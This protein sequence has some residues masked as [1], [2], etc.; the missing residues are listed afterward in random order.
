MEMNYWNIKFSL[1]FHTTY[2]LILHINKLM[3]LQDLMLHVSSHKHY[4]NHKNDKIKWVQQKLGKINQV[5]LRKTLTYKVTIKISFFL[6]I[7]YLIFVII[8][9]FKFGIIILAIIQ[10]IQIFEKNIYL[11]CV[12]EEINRYQMY[13]LSQICYIFGL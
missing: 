9:L 5:L 13:I 11:V 4:N 3:Q 12:S 8:S 10:Q 1:P 2:L 6:N 7:S